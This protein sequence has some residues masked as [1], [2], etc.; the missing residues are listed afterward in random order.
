M[1]DWTPLLLT[2][3]S[4]NLRRIVL[5]ELLEKPQNDPEVVEVTL[6]REEDPLVKQLIAN[7]QDDGSWTP[8]VIEGSYHRNSFQ[9]TSD[10]LRRLAFLGFTKDHATVRSAAEYLFSHQ[11][12][13]GSWPILVSRAE[14]D[15][16][17][18]YTAIPLQT[19]LPLG[20]VATCGYSTDHRSEKAYD[21]LLTQRLEDGS[22]P[23]GV[24][25]TT[26][27]GFRA[28]YRKIPHSRWGCRSNTTAAVLCFAHHPTRRHDEATRLAMDLLLGCVNTERDT[29]GFEVARL[30]GAEVTRG[31][32]T[33]HAKLDLLL[34]LDLAGRTG[35]SDVDPRFSNLLRMVQDWR[36][37]HGT[38]E[39]LPKPQASRWVTL[40]TLRAL[41]RAKGDEK[42][43][44][45]E[46]ITPYKKYSRLERRF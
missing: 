15:G 7:Q 20:S 34:L 18:T 35:I 39:Y 2:D 42:W 10:V 14:A 22:W 9:V 8:G 11:Q 43:V 26:V 16:Y 27:K 3:P 1:T 13:D 32:L 5:T 6:N 29:F 36:T 41:K 21:W 12:E 30:V 46:P 40:E 33:Y 17:G 44:G 31:Y 38:W 23:T 24:T 4:P 28:G 37:K 19:A 25:Q 45:K